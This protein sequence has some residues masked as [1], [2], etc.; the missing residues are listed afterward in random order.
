M[1][2]KMTETQLRATIDFLESPPGSAW[3]A[4]GVEVTMSEDSIRALGAAAR[5]RLCE[6]LTCDASGQPKG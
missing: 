6:S 4:A 5:R 3:V 2:S 1:A